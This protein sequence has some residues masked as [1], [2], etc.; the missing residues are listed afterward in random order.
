MLIDNDT[1]AL[2]NQEL[3]ITFYNENQSKS[4]T[5]H[6]DE[7]GVSEIQIN[8]NPGNYTV[9]VEYSGNEKYSPCET[10][11]KIIINK[12]NTL[13]IPQNISNDEIQKLIDSSNGS[14][15]IFLGENYNNISLIINK[16]LNM[17]KIK[18]NKAIIIKNTNKK[19]KPKK[20]NNK[21]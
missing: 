19:T 4:Y 17:K 8:F 7:K 12:N 18:E 5:V 3:L 2:D 14:A 13:Y 1:N 16:P 10:T 15:I 9:K 11:N 6:T 21:N 20:K